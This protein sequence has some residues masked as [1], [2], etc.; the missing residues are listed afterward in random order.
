MSCQYCHLIGYHASGCPN[1]NAPPIIYH[2]LQCNELIRQGDIY[3]IDYKNDNFCSEECI[4]K[5]YDIERIEW[6]E[7]E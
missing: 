2:C 4:K 1:A 7:D 6:Y 5:Y 3:Y